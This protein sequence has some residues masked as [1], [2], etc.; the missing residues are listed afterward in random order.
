MGYSCPKLGNCLNL[1]FVNHLCHVPSNIVNSI[2]TPGHQYVS[3]VIRTEQTDIRF[4][5][6]CKLVG[7]WDRTLN[8]FCELN[9]VDI[10]H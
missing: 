1:I 8:D 5:H 4:T 7:S 6:N 2:G 9:S 10:F 3:V